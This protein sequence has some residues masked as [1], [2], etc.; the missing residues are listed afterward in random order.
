[1][2]TQKSIAFVVR[3]QM[4]YQ[5]IDKLERKRITKLVMRELFNVADRFDGSPKMKITFLVRGNA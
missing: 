5:S 3:K 1:M 2:V 4:D